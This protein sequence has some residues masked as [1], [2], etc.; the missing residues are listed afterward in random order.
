MYFLVSQR[1]YT[2]TYS[3]NIFSNICIIVVL[4][5][6]IHNKQYSNISCIAFFLVVLYI[7]FF[8]LCYHIVNFL[9]SA[10]FISLCCKLWNDSQS[11]VPYKTSREL[12]DQLILHNLSSLI[13]IVSQ[14]I[15]NR[16]N[17]LTWTPLISQPITDH[18]I[19]H[20][21]SPAWFSFTK[22]SLYHCWLDS[23]FSYS[24]PVSQSFFRSLL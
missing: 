1:T 4:D 16:R 6:W 18:V 8:V 14:P 17:L 9:L 5:T 2:Q 7:N 24:I 12:T 15:F 10:L 23:V 21:L 19:S 20:S 13:K 22:I 3:N 11:F